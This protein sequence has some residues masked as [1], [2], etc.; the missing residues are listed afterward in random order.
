VT[1][2]FFISLSFF[3]V[4]ISQ[5]AAAALQLLLSEISLVLFSSSSSSSAAAAGSEHSRFLELHFVPCLFDSHFN[6]VI[7]VVIFVFSFG[8]SCVASRVALSSFKEVC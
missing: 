4:K 3:V 6:A 7:L 5:A 8:L 2:I 1:D